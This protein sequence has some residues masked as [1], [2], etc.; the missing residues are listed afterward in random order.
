MGRRSSGGSGF[1]KKPSGGAPPR[2]TATAAPPRQAPTPTPSST[3]PG[4]G[5][6][7]MEGMAFGAGSEVAHQAVRGVMGSGQSEGYSQ[8]ADYAAPCSNENQSFMSCLQY[9]KSDISQ[10]Q[11]YLDLFKQCKGAN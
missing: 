9:N 11:N 2:S 6:I 7:M 4:F 3:Q 8:Q 5:R 1:F 10:C